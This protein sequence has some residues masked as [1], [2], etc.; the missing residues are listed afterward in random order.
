MM[1]TSKSNFGDAVLIGKAWVSSAGEARREE[2]REREADQGGL[3]PRLQFTTGAQPIGSG[4]FREV[5]FCY[6]RTALRLSWS[7]IGPS[8]PGLRIGA[9][10]PLAHLWR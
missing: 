9:M 2:E 8:L 3:R 4:G 5:L 7:I 6:V 10:L 1:A